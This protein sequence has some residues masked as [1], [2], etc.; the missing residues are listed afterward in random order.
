MIYI[1]LLHNKHVYSARNEKNQQKVAIHLN[2][3][4]TKLN[5]L[6]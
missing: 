3:N 6:T 5:R 1:S 4:P 2:K